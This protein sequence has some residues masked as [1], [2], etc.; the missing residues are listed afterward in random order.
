M[1]KIKRIAIVWKDELENQGRSQILFGDTYSFNTEQFD[2]ISVTQKKHQQ[3]TENA[4]L[5]KV[6]EQFSTA[7]IVRKGLSTFIVKE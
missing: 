7:K 5:N 3:L 6:K 2:A 4:L 1:N